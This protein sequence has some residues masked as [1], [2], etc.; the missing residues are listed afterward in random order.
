MT[1]TYWLALMARYEWPA[2]AGFGVAVILAIPSAPMLRY[3]AIYGAGALVAYS[4]VPY[5]TP[6]CIISI[7]WPFTLLFG[8]GAAWLAER[9]PRIATGA[10]VVLLGASLYQSIQLNFRNFTNEKEPYVYVQT[11]SEI[12]TLTKPLLD[13][14]RK[15]PRFYGIS[16][17]IL[18]ESYYPLPWVLGDFTGLGYYNQDNFP[19][20]HNVDVIVVDSTRAEEIRA[21]LPEPYYWREFRLRDAQGPS[22]VFFRQARFKDW[23]TDK[24]VNF[25][26]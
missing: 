25:V 3:I 6:W 14:A 4:L 22:T 8:A 20:S 5:K 24:A 23:F 17:Q 13:S 10:I 2:L 21:A 15:D 1:N 16:G 9:W 12:E 18:L 26:K 7:I 19:S 11:Y